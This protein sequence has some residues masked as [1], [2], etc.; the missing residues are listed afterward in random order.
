MVTCRFFGAEFLANGRIKKETGG[1]EIA[2]IPGGFSLSLGESHVCFSTKTYCE[3]S[4]EMSQGD[5]SN[6]SS[7]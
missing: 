2:K 5:S 1:R 6:E 7:Q 3:P 4:L